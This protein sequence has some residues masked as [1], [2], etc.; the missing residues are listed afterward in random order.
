MRSGRHQLRPYSTAR[1]S[2]VESAEPTCDAFAREVIVTQWMRIC[3]ASSF[4][5]TS[6]ISLPR[7][8]VTSQIPLRL[9]HRPP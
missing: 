4:F 1:R 5:E 6:L 2:A 3:R 7:E 9:A 8:T